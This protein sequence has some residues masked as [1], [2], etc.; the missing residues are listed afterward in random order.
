MG[1]R[2]AVPAVLTAG[3]VCLSSFAISGCNLANGKKSQVVSKDSPWYESASVEVGETF[4]DYELWFTNG[5][6]VGP[7]G[8]GFLVVEDVNYV[9]PDDFDY[10]ND[11]TKKY[12]SFE[13]EYYSKT[14][15]LLKTVNLCDKLEFENCE[16]YYAYVC[17]GEI[18]V[19]LADTTDYNYVPCEG[20]FDL[21]SESFTKIEEKSMYDGSVVPM[22]NWKIGDYSVTSFWL[23]SSEG[24]PTYRFRVYDG[25][26]KEYE[27]VMS[28]ALPEIMVYNIKSYLKIDDEN[29]LF[30]T[31]VRFDT[32]YIKLNLPSG[33]LTVESKDDWAWLSGVNFDNVYSIDGKGAY[34]KTLSGLRYL[35]CETKTIDDV[36]SFSDCNINRHM[37]DDSALIAVSDGEY[38]FFSCY[39]PVDASK[40]VPDMDGYGMNLITLSKCDTNPNAGKTILVAG[41]LDEETLD[42]PMCEAI[43]NFN[44]TSEKYFVKAEVIHANDQYINFRN[45]ASDDDYADAYYTGYA[46]LCNQLAVDMRSGDGPDIILNA[47]DISQIQNSEFLLN[48]NEYFAGENGIDTSLFFENVV[49]SSETNGG[50]YYMPLNYSVVGIKAAEDEVNTDL[51][52]FTFDDYKTYVDTVCNGADPLNNSQ[53]GVFTELNS[54]IGSESIVDGK[55]NFDNEAFKAAAEYVK[56]NVP[57][58][59]EEPEDEYFEAWEMHYNAEV[60]G[61]YVVDSSLKSYEYKNFGSYVLDVGSIGKNIRLMGA[62]SVDGRGPSIRVGASVGIAATS[63]FIDGAWEFIKTLLGDECQREIAMSGY[64]PISINVFDE[65]SARNIEDYNNVNLEDFSFVFNGQYSHSAE[66]LDESV[67]ET[68]RNILLSANAVIGTDSSVNSIIREEM[69][70]YFAGDKTL[71]EVIS[72]INNRVQ[73]VLDERK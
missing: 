31:S 5:R 72:V 17:N 35:N 26:G 24:E 12:R 21:D 6:Y 20:I 48:L 65:I 57:S 23:T 29:I 1:N 56:D 42:Y 7:Y 53:I 30:L 34:E 25:S 19:D 64:N 13:L 45:M 59:Y 52:G 55:A 2:I 44:N 14:G 8:D 70:A 27:I 33:K 37:F 9:I 3:V 66:P 47:D 43:N 4:D 61:S 58:N 54:Y 10:D 11:S 50:L 18:H 40:V 46:A 49:R 32:E 38:T 67:V 62:P 28:E 16:V 51:P 36:L 63:N 15:E 39:D 69:P 73:V 60:Y 41:T 71:D 22:S 68:Y